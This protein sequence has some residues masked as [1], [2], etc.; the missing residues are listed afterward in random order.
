MWLEIAA[1][2]SLWLSVF[3]AQVTVLDTFVKKELPHSTCVA[4]TLKPHARLSMDGTV[5]L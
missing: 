5:T 4:E 1:A 3:V 2:V